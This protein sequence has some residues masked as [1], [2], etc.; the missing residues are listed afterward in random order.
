MRMDGKV[1]LVTGGGAGIGRAIATRL[2][3]EGARVVVADINDATAAGTVAAITAAG[4]EAAA[5]HGDVAV[6]AGCAAIVDFA[7]SRFGGLHALVNNAGLP[8]GYAEGTPRERWDRGI[9]TSLTS[10]YAMSDLAIP[11]LVAGGGGA[12]VNICS[13][14]GNTAATAVAWYASAKAGVTGLTRSLA[15]TYGGQGVRVNAVCPGAIETD[16][17]RMIRENPEALA[18]WNA[19]TPLGRLGRPEEVAAVAAFLA[20]DDASYVTAHVFFVDGG[21]S[22][23]AAR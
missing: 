6:D 18:A 10:V 19:R 22:V 23:G 15:A 14:A 9:R 20:S 8:S 21:Y 7:V 3:R 16:R 4:G 11:H 1:A 5:V 13:V 17:T 12:I 2:G